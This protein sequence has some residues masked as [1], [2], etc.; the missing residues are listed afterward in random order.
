MADELRKLRDPFLVAVWP[1][2]G[3][4]AL[5][6]G[7]YLLAKLEMKLMTEFSSRELFDVESIEVRGG[8]IV[9]GRMPRSRVFSWSDPNRKHDL[10]LFI[11]ESQP[12]AGK[13]AFCQRLLD[14]AKASGVECVF[15]F[16]AMVTQ[17]HPMHES[18]VFG[19]TTHEHGLNILQQ[20]EL[21]LLEDG[22]IGGLNGVL[23]GAA[24]DMGLE[25]TGLLGEMPHIFTQTSFPKASLAVLRVFTTIAGIDLDFTEMEEQVKTLDQNL[26]K[27]LA[28]L[29][30]RLAQKSEE[31][32]EPSDVSV[33]DSERQSEEDRNRIEQLFQRA[34]ADRSR[35]YELKNEL[36]R[37][38]LFKD[39]EDR[40]LDLFR[41]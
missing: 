31:G 30:R 8:L 9:P 11:G 23:L 21:T 19:V 10:L 41:E 4:I 17:M 16:A 7:Y 15:T 14:F 6:A 40:F 28:Q 18:R 39:Y 26:G 2:M 3:H 37:L 34:A 32:A 33:S 1:G 13:L 25:G 20:L 24:G 29:E 38:G 27:L 36:D 12:P 35:A 22:H 5:A